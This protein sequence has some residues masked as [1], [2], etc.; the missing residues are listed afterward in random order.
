MTISTA[1]DATRNGA[2]SQTS[3]LDLIHSTWPSVIAAFSP[4]NTR[5]SVVRGLSTTYTDDEIKKRRE[6]GI[7]ALTQ[8][9]DGTIHTPPGGGVTSSRQSAKVSREATRIRRLCRE[10]E[11][12]IDAMLSP[13]LASGEL[14]PPVSLQLDQRGSDT[15]AVIDGGR[16]EISLLGWLGVPPL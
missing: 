11:A 16:G 8:R 4:N 12:Q 15:F 5:D 3:A 1:L 13:K 6:A 9:P 7:I 14:T 10:I 2:W